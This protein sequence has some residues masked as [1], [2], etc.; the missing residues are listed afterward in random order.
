MAA[1]L[2]EKEMEEIG[3]IG[4]NDFVRDLRV[5][6]LKIL[7]VECALAALAQYQAP[8]GAA[9]FTNPTSPVVRPSV[10]VTPA[11]EVIGTHYQNA[12]TLLYGMD[13]TERQKWEGAELT[14]DQLRKIV[15]LEAELPDAYHRR[16][17][18]IS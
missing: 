7:V 17:R 1:R 2:K 12:S 6:Q 18:R 15:A 5:W 13:A 14:P 4:G 8:G 11:V 9:G 10:S 3:E 16:F